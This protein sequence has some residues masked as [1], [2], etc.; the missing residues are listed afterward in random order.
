MMQPIQDQIQESIRVK[1]LLLDQTK[2]IELMANVITQSIQN[3]GKLMICGNGGSAGD[4]QHLSTELTIRL[5][6]V[7]ERPAIAAL[8]LTTNTSTITACANDYGYDFIFSRQVEALGK[9]EDVLLGLSTS[10]NS[11]NVILALEAAQTRGIT[12][13]GLTGKSGGKM[14]D[15]CDVIICVD[16]ENPNRIQESHILIGH[17]LCD[18]VQYGLY[19]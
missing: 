13:L 17:I 18:L 19:G 16:S 5:S 6:S 12:T 7:F 15:V 14:K 3:G 8:A 1:Q 2:P 9:P 10:G 11:K 4:S